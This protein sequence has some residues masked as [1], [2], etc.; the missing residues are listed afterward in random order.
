SQGGRLYLSL[1]G[2]LPQ[3]L[4]TSTED[5]AVAQKGDGVFHPLD[6]GA[7]EDALR[8]LDFQ[9]DRVDAAVY[10]LPYPRRA[11]LESAASHG[12]IL[13]APG[14]RPVPATTVHAVVAHEFGHVVQRSLAPE[15]SPAW[16]E[17]LR[18]R[19][20][21]AD[22][23]TGPHAERPVEIFAEDF[24][25]LLG[26]ELA[27][28]DG[29]VENA[30][31]IAPSSLSGLDDFLRDLPERARRTALSGAFAAQ[32]SIAAFPNPFRHA[33]T[34]SAAPALAIGGLAGERTL[35]V[36]DVRGRVVRRQRVAVAGDGSVTWRWEGLDGSGVRLAAGSYFVNTEGEAGRA[37]RIVLTR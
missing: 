4:I 24:R 29:S 31:L 9:V 20:L 36:L 33:V 11:G 14:T 2:E 23:A 15:G 12:A 26:S 1:P 25:A 32:R 3:E 34:L 30:T 35:Q 8:G 17:Y 7:V 6:R 10:V 37:T 16:S 19:G 27:R 22:A 28:G 5:P 18:L 13:L 21:G